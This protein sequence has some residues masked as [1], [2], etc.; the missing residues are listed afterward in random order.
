MNMWFAYGM[1]WLAIGAAVI[2]GLWLTHDANCLWA[3][4]IGT[5]ISVSTKGGSNRDKGGP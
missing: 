5:F 4:L 1:M 3:L 2:V